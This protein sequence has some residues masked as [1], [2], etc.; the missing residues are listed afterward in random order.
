MFCH[1]IQDLMTELRNP[2]VPVHP[3]FSFPQ[4]SRASIPYPSLISPPIHR[5]AHDTRSSYYLED[6]ATEFQVQGLELDWV[7]VNWDGDFRFNGSGWSHH[8]FRGKNWCNISN[9]DNRN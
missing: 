3:L 1:A 2:M 8:D 9:Q 6:A 7:C 5:S 4:S